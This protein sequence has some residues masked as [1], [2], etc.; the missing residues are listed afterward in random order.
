MNRLITTVSTRRFIAL[1][2]KKDLSA[3]RDRV[4]NDLVEA[5][6]QLETARGK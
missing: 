6:S 5:W 1:K 3:E 4:F 2:V